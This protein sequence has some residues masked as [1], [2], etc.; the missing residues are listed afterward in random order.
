[1]GWFSD[2]STL[3][4]LSHYTYSICH[5]GLR[6][7]KNSGNEVVISFARPDEKTHI[8]NR[9]RATIGNPI[10]E[11]DARVSSI[12]LSGFLFVPFHPLKKRHEFHI[13]QAQDSGR[14]GLSNPTNPTIPPPPPPHKQHFISL[15]KIR[16]WGEYGIL[17][18]FSQL[19]K[20]FTKKSYADGVDLLEVLG[21]DLA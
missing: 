14:F 2:G 11:S 1:M 5:S 21:F 15:N 16:S 13:R 17:I 12:S 19:A 18:E 3:E 9:L 20:L 6:R 10:L 4:F 7:V 8:R